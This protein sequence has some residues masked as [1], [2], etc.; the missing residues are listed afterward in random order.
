[1]ISVNEFMH[2]GM[3][4]KIVGQ[5]LVTN[6]ITTTYIIQAFCGDKTNIP[7]EVSSRYEG[8]TFT[9]LKCKELAKSVTNMIEFYKLKELVRGDN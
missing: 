6:E 2:F 3:S 8:T 1:M 9:C 4:N 5:N 7:T